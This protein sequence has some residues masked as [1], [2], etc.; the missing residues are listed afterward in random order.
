MRSSWGQC[1]DRMRKAELSPAVRPEEG[2]S[3]DTA[4]GSPCK[5]RRELSPQVRSHLAEGQG[6]RTLIWDFPAPRAVRNQHLFRK[7]PSLWY[8]LTTA[9]QTKA[10][11]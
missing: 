10:W 1:P 3:E 4:W 5:P 11:A 6:P 9:K 7:S 2:S 8:F